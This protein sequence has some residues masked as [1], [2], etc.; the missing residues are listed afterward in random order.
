[1]AIDIRIM[2]TIAHIGTPAGT[3]PAIVDIGGN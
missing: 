3:V 1:M 2:A